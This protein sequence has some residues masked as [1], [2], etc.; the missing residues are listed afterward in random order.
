[1][2]ILTTVLLVTFVL[3]VNFLHN[4]IYRA[5]T[6][7]DGKLYCWLKVPLFGTLFKIKLGSCELPRPQR[8]CLRSAEIE[9]DAYKKGYTNL[10]F[11]IDITRCAADQINDNARYFRQLSRELTMEL[12]EV[13][14]KLARYETPDNVFQFNDFHNAG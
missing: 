9:R 5:E 1:M 11:Q 12:D 14:L 2:F 4:P 7:I 3:A 6:V 13:A 8:E 10:L